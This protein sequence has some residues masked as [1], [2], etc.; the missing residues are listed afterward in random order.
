[1]KHRTLLIASA[2]AWPFIPSCEQQK[3][4]TVVHSNDSS[5]LHC[6]KCSTKEE[7]I[8]E[9][10][11][12]GQLIKDLSPHAELVALENGK[13]KVYLY[14]ELMQPIEPKDQ[15]LS[16][17]TGEAI[18]PVEL[19]FVTSDNTFL[20][21]QALPEGDKFPTTLTIKNTQSSETSSAEFTLSRETCNEACD[22]ATCEDHTY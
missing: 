19:T 15:T 21:E 22:D 6:S 11:N 17:T 20:S 2:L 14:D 3:Q 8:V 10:P 16:I 12:H 4:E 5:C 18:S 9:G 1:M 7:K 13:L